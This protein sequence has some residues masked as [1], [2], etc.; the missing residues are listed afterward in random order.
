M[1][2]IHYENLEIL[3]AKFRITI[4]V[5]KFKISTLSLKSLNFPYCMGNTLKDEK[6]MAFSGFQE[7]LAA[8]ANFDL[9]MYISCTALPN[10][11]KNK[12]IVAFLDFGLHLGPF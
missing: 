2:A 7:I 1:A 5:A 12:E 9:R 4:L 8:I 10:D 6:N 3:F 11:L